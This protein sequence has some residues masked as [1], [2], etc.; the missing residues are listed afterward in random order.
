M[1]N[2]CTQL[3]WHWVLM[4]LKSG[5]WSE[6]IKKNHCGKYNNYLI[7]KKFPVVCRTQSCHICK[8]VLP[9]PV[10]SQMVSSNAKVIYVIQ[11]KA[12]QLDSKIFKW[13]HY[14]ARSYALIQFEGGKNGDA[15]NIRRPVSPDNVQ[16]LKKIHLW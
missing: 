14:S 1:Y 9:D 12:Y 15:Q 16:F 10:L 3:M 5:K 4:S 2:Q 11:N 6:L 7:V 8:H 13:R